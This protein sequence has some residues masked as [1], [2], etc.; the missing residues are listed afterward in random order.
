MHESDDDLDRLDSV[1][2]SS[3]ERAGPFIRKSFDIPEKSIQAAELVQRMDGFRTIALAVATSD[4]RPIV[5]PVGSV[6]WQGEF[7]VPTVASSTKARLVRSQPAVSL[8][9]YEEDDFAVLVQGEARLVSGGDSLFCSLDE[10]LVGRFEESTN[11]W[12]RKG[13]GVFIVVRP[14]RL[15]TYRTGPAEARP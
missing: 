11:D 4:G 1:I 6:L 2:V 10:Y 14:T 5:S 7:A 9:Y 15:M 8:T 12:G 3:I 13:E